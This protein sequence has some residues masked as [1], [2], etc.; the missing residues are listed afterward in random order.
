MQAQKISFKNFTSRELINF[1]RL[2]Q[3]REFAAVVNTTSTDK[4]FNIDNSFYIYGTRRTLSA[5]KRIQLRKQ[6][7][8]LGINNEQSIV[9]SLFPGLVS[10]SVINFSQLTKRRF[11]L[12]GT[13]Y[14]LKI[15]PLSSVK[16]SK[17]YFENQQ[18]TLKQVTALLNTFH[19][20]RFDDNAG[21]NFI[22]SF[23]LLP[24]Q[25]GTKTPR[26]YSDI[27]QSIIR[28]QDPKEEMVRLQLFYL[29]NV[30]FSIV[31]IIKLFIF[32]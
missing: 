8:T 30:L 25:V 15:T 3:S 12:K 21:M 1:Q 31:Y 11:Y 32:C 2:Y 16:S 27:K 10:Q 13:S 6:L 14:Q 5:S 23:V 17:N 18:K 28:Y 22:P 4:T 9:F 24:S 7:M 26:L 20:F 19:E 29:I